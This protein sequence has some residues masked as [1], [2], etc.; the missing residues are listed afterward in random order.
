MI[1]PTC[2]IAGLGS[3]LKIGKI[4]YIDLTKINGLLNFFFFFG[5]I[6]ILNNINFY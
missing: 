1:A 6:I 5:Q 2:I 3:T 4:I